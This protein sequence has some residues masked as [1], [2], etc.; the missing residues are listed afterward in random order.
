MRKAIKEKL[1]ALGHKRWKLWA[2]GEEKNDDDCLKAAK[3]IV[4]RCDPEKNIKPTQ[5]CVLK[6]FIQDNLYN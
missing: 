1:A 5:I 3:K 4:L 6:I 2:S